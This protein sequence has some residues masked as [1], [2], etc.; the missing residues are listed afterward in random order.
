MAATP[1]SRAST[2][3]SDSF[4]ADERQYNNPRRRPSVLGV[5]FK[6]GGVAAGAGGTGG[7]R[8]IPE[9][10]QSRPQRV[11]KDEGGEATKYF[12]GDEP[13]DDLK[14]VCLHFRGSE[15]VKE[16]KVREGAG[17]G[18]PYPVKQSKGKKGKSKGILSWDKDGEKGKGKKTKARERDWIPGFGLKPKD[19]GRG[20]KEKEREAAVLKDSVSD[21]KSRE[22]LIPVASTEEHGKST[23]PSPLDERIT[24]ARGSD[25]VSTDEDGETEEEGEDEGEYQDPPSADDDDE[26]SVLSHVEPP[27]PSLHAHPQEELQDLGGEVSDSRSLPASDGVSDVETSESGTGVGRIATRYRNPYGHIYDSSQAANLGLPSAVEPQPIP[28]GEKQ[29][30]EQGTQKDRNPGR[31]RGKPDWVVLDM[32]TDI[33]VYHVLGFSTV[34]PHET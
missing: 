8:K 34:R 14:I 6:F 7:G 17:E 26:K 16:G 12:V 29:D 15:P 11:E 22:G 24:F 28:E 20:R 4:R 25:L 18:N 1:P 10:G 9:D 33:G 19:K 3:D 31:E 2:P 27:A 32:G 30:K 23:E 13:V 5:D 21:P